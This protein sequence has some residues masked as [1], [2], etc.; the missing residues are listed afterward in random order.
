M[1]STWW[2]C[3]QTVHEVVL[4]SH[5]WKAALWNTIC[6]SQ[7]LFLTQELFSFPA[8]KLLGRLITMLMAS[9]TWRVDVNA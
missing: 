7:W 2:D 9:S 8:E 1:S 5:T 4:G 3:R 6:L